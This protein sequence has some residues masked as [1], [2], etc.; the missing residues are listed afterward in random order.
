MAMP[1]SRPSLVSISWLSMLDNVVRDQIRSEIDQI[2]ELFAQFAE[3]MD[4][5]LASEPDPVERVALASVLH[6]FYTGVEAILLTVAKRVDE[7][8]PSGGSWHRELLDQSVAATDLRP[9]VVSAEVRTALDRY[10]AFRHFF[11]QAYSFLLGWERR[12]DLVADARRTWSDAKGE[13]DGWLRETQ[14]PF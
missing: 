11:R 3:L 14:A 13:I 5:S 12:R 10:L 1:G 8:V 6:S 7:C 2:D 4:S 9:A